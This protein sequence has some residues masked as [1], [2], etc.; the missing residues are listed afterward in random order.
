LLWYYVTDSTY[1]VRGKRKLIDSDLIFVTFPIVMTISLTL[2][3]WIREY[4]L[5][6]ETKASRAE[7]RYISSITTNESDRGRER[8]RETH[9]PRS[10]FSV[11]ATVYELSFYQWILVISHAAKYALSGKQTRSILPTFRSRYNYLRA[12]FR[13]D[14]RYTISSRISDNILVY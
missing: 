3:H 10:F 11:I 9:N 12:S 13:D 4:S 7:L 2:N 1:F 5:S 6:G 14:T 8:E